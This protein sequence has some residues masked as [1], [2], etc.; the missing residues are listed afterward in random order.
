ME[1]N[2]QLFGLYDDIVGKVM[3]NVQNQAAYAKGKIILWDFQQTAPTDRLYY[4][5]ACIVSDL[6]N[7]QIYLQMP[8]FEYLKFKR[9]RKSRKNLH[10]VSRKA[11]WVSQESKTSVY[12]IMD[13]IREFFDI[14]ISLFKD[15][16]D[17]YYG[18]IE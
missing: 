2:K 9:K 11:K 8:L 1:E 13:F 14:D 4:N 3:L 17:T 12:I 5:V 18:W 6:F 16:N 7:M 15:I 10:W